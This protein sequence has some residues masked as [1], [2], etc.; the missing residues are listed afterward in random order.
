MVAAR[1]YADGIAF[2]VDLF[3]F[4]FIF[5]QSSLHRPAVQFAQFSSSTSEYIQI[6]QNSP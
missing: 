3:D 1:V 5:Q 6:H 2:G 4:L